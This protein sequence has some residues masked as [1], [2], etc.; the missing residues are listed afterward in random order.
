MQAR[1]ALDQYHRKDRANRRQYFFLN[2]LEVPRLQSELK[3]RFI[4]VSY[5]FRTLLEVLSTNL[6]M[7]Q[8]CVLLDSL[9]YA[10]MQWY[11]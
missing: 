9:P 8:N 7:K 4:I 2:L 3:S 5:A 1:S 11:C 10:A 6:I